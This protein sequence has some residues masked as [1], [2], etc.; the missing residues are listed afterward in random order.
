LVPRDNR[1]LEKLVVEAL[2]DDFVIAFLTRGFAACTGAKRETAAS[3]RKNSTRNFL[4]D[5]V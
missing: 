4:I 3:E 5:L 1:A 2:A